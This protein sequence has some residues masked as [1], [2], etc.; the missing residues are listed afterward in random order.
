MDKLPSGL[1][2]AEPDTGAENAPGLPLCHYRDHHGDGSF[3][4]KVAL[5]VVSAGDCRACSIPEAVAHRDACL[6]LVPLRHQGEPQYACKWFFSG[7]NEPVVDDWRKLCF[8]PYWF[9]RHRNETFLV[10]YMADTRA[11]YLRVLRGEEPR[12][13]TRKSLYLRDEA[14]TAS[15]SPLHRWWSELLKQLSSQRRITHEHDDD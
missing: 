1:S 9:P 15:K 7:A 6:Y 5:S 8:C 4:C 14:S 2:R 11:R 3:R 12:H 13:R 10:H